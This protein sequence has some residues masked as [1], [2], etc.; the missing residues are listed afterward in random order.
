MPEGNTARPSYNTFY[1]TQ[2]HK[3]VFLKDIDSQRG[4]DRKGW[5]NLDGWKCRVAEKNNNLDL[6]QGNELLSAL[7]ASDLAAEVSAEFNGRLG[8]G[9]DVPAA[10][11]NVFG[12][13]RSAMASP[14]DGP[15]VLI[16]LAVLQLR[17]GHLQAVIRDAAIDLIESGEAL[18]AYRSE[19]SSQR[20]TTRQILEQLVVM[21]GVTDVAA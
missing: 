6:P 3:P 11:A 13:F 20:K 19:D 8:M 10:T 2:K 16:A 9:F 5:G 21:L 18:G 7:L 14:Q 4:Y 17:E 1:H 15:V 12:K